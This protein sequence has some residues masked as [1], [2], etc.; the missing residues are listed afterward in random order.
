M[1]LKL[2]TKVA[3]AFTGPPIVVASGGVLNV[4]VRAL[5]IGTNAKMKMIM[6][7]M[8]NRFIRFS[9]FYPPP[10]AEIFLE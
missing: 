2:V 4:I 6:G 3:E 1:L 7:K 5:A 9:F 8:S 10:E